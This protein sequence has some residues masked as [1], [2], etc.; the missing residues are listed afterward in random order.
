MLLILGAL[1]LLLTAR[2]FSVQFRV[3]YRSKCFESEG[4]VLLK[5]ELTDGH[6][7][8][9]SSPNLPPGW[10][11]NPFTGDIEGIAEAGERLYPCIRD[12]R[13]GGRQHH[14]ILRGSPTFHQR[15]P[16]SVEGCETH[17]QHRFRIWDSFVFEQR[18]LLDTY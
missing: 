4:P 16:F 6:G 15:P 1:V 14:G 11:I 18:E 3:A 5:R 12:D 17:H 9:F 10:S 2:M 7:T 8:G 13:S